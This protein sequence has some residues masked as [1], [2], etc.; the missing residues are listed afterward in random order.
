MRHLREVSHVAFPHIRL[1]REGAAIYS[2]DSVYS[3]GTMAEAVHGL[4]RENTQHLTDI[5]DVN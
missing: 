4:H 5:Q 2:T 3:G 1:S